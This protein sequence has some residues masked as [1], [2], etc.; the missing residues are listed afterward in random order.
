[1]PIIKTKVV[2]I[3][4]FTCVLLSAC[5]GLSPYSGETGRPIKALAPREVSGLKAGE[6]M[7]Y[8]KAAELNQYPGPMHVLE[9]AAGLNLSA[10]QKLLT[11]NL[12]KSHKAEARALG[13]ELIAAET[14]LDALFRD[15]LVSVE[16]V[17]RLTLKIGEIQANLRA[18]HL[19]T[20]LQQTALLNP[21]QISEYQKLRGY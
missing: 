16:S 12:L 2:L 18:S 11:A 8:A 17:K 5:A 3:V 6:G 13:E 15:K 9:L 20:H 1:M 19:L 7:G 4:C 21:V 14:E 10:E